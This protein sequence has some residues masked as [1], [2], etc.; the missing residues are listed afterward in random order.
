MGVDVERPTPDRWSVWDRRLRDLGLFV[1][2]AVLTVNE[3]VI[4]ADVRIAALPFLAGLLSLP[5]ALRADER[6]QRR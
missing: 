3:F 4:R 1:L 5:L 6:N 2:G